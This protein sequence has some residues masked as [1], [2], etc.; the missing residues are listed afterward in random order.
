M[1]RRGGRLNRPPSL[2]ESWDHV[3]ALQW[4]RWGSVLAVV[5]PSAGC[6][7][8]RCMAGMRYGRADTRAKN[9]LFLNP[10]CTRVP[11]RLNRPC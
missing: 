7:G 5:D 11:P 10:G 1:G 9:L 2:S 3:S 4:G 8:A 6:V